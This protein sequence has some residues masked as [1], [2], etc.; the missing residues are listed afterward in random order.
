MAADGPKHSGEP[1]R[2]QA[3][4]CSMSGTRTAS[5]LRGGMSRPGLLN[6]QLRATPIC[7]RS[8]CES[9]CRNTRGVIPRALRRQPAQYVT[10]RR[11]RHVKE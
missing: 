11:L 2:E 3:P 1:I 4:R 10:H 9:I 7:T 6:T 5:K 8:C